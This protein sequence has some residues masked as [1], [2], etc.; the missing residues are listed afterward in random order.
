M[1]PEI[2]YKYI[3]IYVND[4]NDHLYIY[5]YTYISV[6]GKKINI[7]F[8]TISFT[9][10]RSSSKLLLY[11]LQDVISNKFNRLIYDYLIR[12]CYCGGI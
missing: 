3:C 2:I 5:L 12:I 1:L 6:L 11:S 10:F 8:T 4:V 9:V 7:R